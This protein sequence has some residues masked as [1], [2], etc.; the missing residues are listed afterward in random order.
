MH[1]D[2]L[3]DNEAIGHEFADGLAGVGVGD[4]TDFIGVE[5]DLALTAAGHGGRQALL[6]AEIH[7]VHARKEIVSEFAQG[8]RIEGMAPED[9]CSSS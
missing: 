5:P 1:G 4:L 8:Q 2:L 3:A 6:R 9:E 7:P